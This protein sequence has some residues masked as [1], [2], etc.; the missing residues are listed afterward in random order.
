MILES[1]VGLSIIVYASLDSPA[2][3]PVPPP[4]PSSARHRDAA[5]LPLVHRAAACVLQRI[6]DDP[7]SRAGRRAGEVEAL[8][9]TAMAGCA[10][11]L[12]AV[13]HAHDRMYGRGSGEAFL[14]G[15]FMDVLPAAVAQLTR[16]RAGADPRGN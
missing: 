5:L 6:A 14:R 1:I 7:G 3:E 16:M 2:P 11:P 9:V 10:R 13:V 8:I 12:R 4:P 15:P